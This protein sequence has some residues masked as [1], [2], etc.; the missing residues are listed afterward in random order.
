MYMVDLQALPC[1]TL[2]TWD[3]DG[4]SMVCF[5]MASS[6]LNSGRRNL[7]DFLLIGVHWILNQKSRFDQWF[8]IRQIGSQFRQLATFE[9][10]I[11]KEYLE[12]EKD[13]VNSLACGYF[14][15]FEFFVGKE[16]LLYRCR[17]CIGQND[18]LATISKLG[19]FVLLYPSTTFG[20]RSNFRPFR[21]LLWILVISR[22]V[23]HWKVET[24][25]IAW[26]SPSSGHP[27][28]KWNF[29]RYLFMSN[30][31]SCGNVH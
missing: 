3:N 12:L 2:K 13:H 6:G 18:Q 23:F 8:Q 29:F 30:D 11:R 31:F 20:S 4:S 10:V 19:V 25:S 28:I 15:I 27:R 17:Y 21:G 1:Q 26:V 22:P 7:G 5:S 16:F 14:R 24:H 9:M